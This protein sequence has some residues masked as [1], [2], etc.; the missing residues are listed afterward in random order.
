VVYRPVRGARWLVAAISAG[1][2]VAA[3]GIVSLTA[4]GEGPPAAF[5]ALWLAALAWNAYW[6]LFRVCIEVRVEGPSVGWA[7]PVRR[8]TAPLDDVV[9]VRPSRVSR[10]LAVIELRDRRALLVPVRYG[11]AGVE[12]AIR[13][14]APG[15]VI[16]G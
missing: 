16:E 6:W 1:L 12:A 3:V 14:G 2:T 5:V 4:R 8:G 11:Y 13:A 15:A 9:R 7:T 10:Q